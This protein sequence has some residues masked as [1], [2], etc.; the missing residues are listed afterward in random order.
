MI[1]CGTGLLWFTNTPPDHFLICD[2]SAISRTTYAD[3]FAL[4]GII[5]GVGD[6]S[7]TFNLPDFK[8]RTPI[9]SGTGSGLTPRTLGNKIGEEIH[10]LTAAEN[11]QHKHSEHVGEDASAFDS[12][13]GGSGYQ[14]I[15]PETTGNGAGPLYTD[16]SGSGTGHNN[17]QPSLCVNFIIAFEDIAD[18]EPEPVSFLWDSNQYN[19]IISTIE[20]VIAA[21]EDLRFNNISLDFGRFHITLT[22]Q[23]REYS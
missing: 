11:G 12:S 5:W 20:G 21:T 8:G 10:A 17:I 23:N 2:G 19:T 14:G 7:T 22:G 3:L 16:N 1:K 13:F 9:G 18:P 15:A 6:G 4:L